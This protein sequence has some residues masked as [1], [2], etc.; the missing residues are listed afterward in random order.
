MHTGD[1]PLK[2]YI[3]DSNQPPAGTSSVQESLEVCTVKQL[4]SRKTHC[5]H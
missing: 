3:A 5:N 1:K 4:G 2:E